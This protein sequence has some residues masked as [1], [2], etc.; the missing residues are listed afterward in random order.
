MNIERL[1]QK[2]Q[3]T[4]RELNRYLEIGFNVAMGLRPMP[5]HTE[6]TDHLNSLMINDSLISG[7]VISITLLNLKN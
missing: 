4:H 1:M 2:E 3:M 6:F 7:Y 5:I